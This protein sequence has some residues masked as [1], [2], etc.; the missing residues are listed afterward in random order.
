MPLFF[1]IN[2]F[3]AFKEVIATLHDEAEVNYA[4]MDALHK[5]GDLNNALFGHCL[6]HAL[7]N[8]GKQM[9][10]QQV[11]EFLCHWN[12]LISHSVLA[13]RVYLGR[14]GH[15]APRLTNSIRW[16]VEWEEVRDLSRDSKNDRLLHFLDHFIA[17]RGSDA[18]P[19]VTWCRD[20]L[21]NANTPGLLFDMLVITEHGR[22]LC[23]A[24]YFLEGDGFLWPFAAFKLEQC[25]ASI[26][27]AVP[28][29]ANE[30]VFVQNY[31][32]KVG[33]AFNDVTRRVWRDRRESILAPAHAWLRRIMPSPEPTPEPGARNKDFSRF[34]IRLIIFLN[35]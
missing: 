11:H 35:G 13:Q 18:P 10:S 27:P 6:S 26:D 30:D 15:S 9:R 8:A 32:K 22:P 29:T 16:Y 5:S 17:E 7:S 25:L 23:K 4:A 3:S 1:D 31:A 24:C 33:V 14:L 2:Q 19:S 28:L 20:S 21:Q 34:L 12:Q